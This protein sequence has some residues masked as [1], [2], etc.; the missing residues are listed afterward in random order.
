MNLIID[1]IRNPKYKAELALLYSSGIR[2]SELSRL[3]CG[4]IHHSRQCI[5][6]SRSKNRSDRYAVL[7]EKAFTLLT[8]YIRSCHPHAA[9]EDWLF[10]GQR[11]GS[12]IHQHKIPSKSSL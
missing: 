3:K 9:K 10:P 4:D 2:V 12:H 8:V 6:I 11:A 7:S 5:Y 1:S